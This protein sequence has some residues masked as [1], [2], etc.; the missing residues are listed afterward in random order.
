MAGGRGVEGYALKQASLSDLYTKQNWLAVAIE[1]FFRYF[2]IIF[3]G[4]DRPFKISQSYY[5]YIT[6]VQSKKKKTQCLTCLKY[7][8][9]RRVIQF[10]H[11]W[12]PGCLLTG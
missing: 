12:F 4:N 11:L 2:Q 9:A 5:M 8:P 1:T 3:W 6:P 7:P 10:K